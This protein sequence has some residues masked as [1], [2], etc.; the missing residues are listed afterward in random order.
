MYNKFLMKSVMQ[1]KDFQRLKNEKILPINLS[2]YLYT[3]V[4]HINIILLL[5]HISLTPSG[6][7]SSSISLLE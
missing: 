1:L 2:Y 5:S 3:V 7:L 4:S 6:H